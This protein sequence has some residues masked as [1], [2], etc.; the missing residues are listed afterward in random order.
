MPYGAGNRLPGE[1]ASKLGHLAVIQSEWVRTL[2][3]EFERTDSKK[4][5]PS[6]TLWTSFD[7]SDGEPLLNVWAVDGSFVPVESLDKPPRQVAFVKTALLTVDR[8]KLQAIDKETPHPL[9]LRDVMTDS[10]IFHATVFPLKNV[11]S[12]LGSNYETVRHIVRDSM[13]V[14]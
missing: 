7:P 5:D 1:S 4:N 13:R 11:R 3:E 8:S 12:S 2:V 6:K 9:L 10:A 14:D